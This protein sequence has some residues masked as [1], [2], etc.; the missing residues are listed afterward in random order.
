MEL[1]TYTAW[2]SG[3][4][5]TWQAL[6]RF[7]RNQKTAIGGSKDIPKDGIIAVCQQK[8]KFTCSL[9]SVTQQWIISSASPAPPSSALFASSQ[10]QK[11]N[12]RA[13]PHPLGQ[14]NWREL[15]WGPLG[16]VFGFRFYLTFLVPSELQNQET[17]SSQ[18]LDLDSDTLHLLLAH[19]EQGVHATHAQTLCPE[20]LQAYFLL[21]CQCCQS[22]AESI[23]F[24]LNMR[25]GGS[26]RGEVTHPR[27]QAE[28]SHLLLKPEK[29]ALVSPVPCRGKSLPERPA[30]TNKMLEKE[31]VAPEVSVVFCW[32][33]SVY[34]EYSVYA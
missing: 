28:P 23:G 16:W 5:Q 17:S 9:I 26:W 14:E 10:I 3:G 34:L 18:C 29:P 8:V 15:G 31:T 32:V 13:F 6:S 2:G 21:L 20:A 33:P 12:L 7:N 27:S 30:Q 19:V 24:I 1:K 22:W 11:I 25:K 4:F